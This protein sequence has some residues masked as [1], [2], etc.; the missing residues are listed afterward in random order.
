[1]RIDIVTFDLGGTTI[2]DTANVGAVFS[3]VLQ[4]HGIVVADEAL[5]VVRGASKRRVIEELA[6]RTKQSGIDTE[7]IYRAFQER[8]LQAFAANGV[9]AIPGIEETFRNLRRLGITTALTT[10][11]DRRVTEE[12]LSRL[13]WKGLVDCVVTADDVE[14]G[15]PSPDMILHAMRRTGVTDPAAVAALGDTINDL[16]A[17]AAA[18]VGVAI[19]VLTGAHSRQQLESVPHTAI[20][21]DATEL[22]QWLADH[23]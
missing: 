11:F 5:S 8:L 22:P 18:H 10:G 9:Q 7:E 17:A 2:R 19:G 20:L 4:Q 23:S 15:R 14:N 21:Q 12:L 13:R 16:N 1:M 6:A 3:S